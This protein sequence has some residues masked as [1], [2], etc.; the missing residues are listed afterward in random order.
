MSDFYQRHIDYLTEHAVTPDKLRYIDS[1][2]IPHH[3]FNADHY[4][5]DPFHTVPQK[6]NDAVLKYSADT[7]NKYGTLPWSIQ[8]QYYRL[9]NAFKN[10]DT[11]AILHASAFL[12]HYVADACVPLHLT[13]NHDGQLTHQEGIHAL[14]ESR[15]PEQFGNQYNFYAGKAHY[16]ENPLWQAFII[17]RS[18]YK[19]VDSV[20]R[21]ERQLSKTFPADQKYTTVMRGKRKLTDYSPTYCRAYQKALNGMVQRR[22]RMAIANIGNY[23]YSAWVDAGQPDLNK[24]IDT[25]LTLL[26]KQALAH[27]ALLYRQGKAGMLPNH[28]LVNKTIAD[29]KSGRLTKTAP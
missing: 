4:G 19:C 16:L 1:T 11:S 18:S 20:L 26:H 29:E 23:W 14:W 9:V 22:A 8:Y 28:G 2:E 17:C 21:I 5:K 10:H 15:L 3:F 25:P 13:Q 27:E 7:L 12:G 6:W 24:L